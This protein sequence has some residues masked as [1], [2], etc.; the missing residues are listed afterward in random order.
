MSQNVKLFICAIGLIIITSVTTAL[1]TH[2]S[3][4]PL[5]PETNAT[6]TSQLNVSANPTQQTNSPT[7]ITLTGTGQTATNK[8][9]L[10]EGLATFK[11]THNGQSNFIVHLLD[12]QGND[13]FGSLV[14]VIGSFSGSKAL[15]I[16]A[17]GQYLL[18]IQ[19]DGAWTVT[20]TQ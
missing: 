20:I 14:N 6:G 12:D 13:D 16:P 10:Q 15:Q 4:K 1:V 11:M 9:S 18:D 8:F 17:S 3:Q 2:K 19:A 7:P 5:E